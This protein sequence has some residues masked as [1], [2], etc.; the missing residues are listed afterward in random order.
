MENLNIVTLQGFIGNN[1]EI[2]KISDSKTVTKVSIAYNEVY[3]ADG[4]LR[5]K[6]SWFRVTF[7]NKL[8]QEAHQA[9]TK[10]TPVKIT[11]K[12]SQSSY[13]KDEQTLYTID[14]IANAFE[15]IHKDEV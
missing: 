10:G 7:W 9:L 5:E 6:T 14:I 2:Q 13:E 11:G 15:V 12:L 1:P 8:A 3:K 4:V